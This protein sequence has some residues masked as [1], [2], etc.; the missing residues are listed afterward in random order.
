MAHRH[1]QPLVGKRWVV[2]CFLRGL[3]GQVVGVV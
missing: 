3:E 1:L 2:N